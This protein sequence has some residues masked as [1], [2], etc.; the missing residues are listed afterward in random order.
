MVNE[1]M[2][3]AEEKALAAGITHLSTIE[4]EVGELTALVPDLMEFAFDQLKEGE[5]LRDAKLIVKVVPLLVRC[6]Q[7]SAEFHP[8]D[9]LVA[10]CPTCECR[11]VDVLRG[12]EANLIRLEGELNSAEC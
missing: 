7:C 9:S 12:R 5:L 8:P 10:I 4:V 11:E 6:R 1:I 3:L 2:R